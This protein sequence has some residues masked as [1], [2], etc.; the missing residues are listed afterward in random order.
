MNIEYVLQMVCACVYVN[1]DF[2]VLSLL[3]KVT[4]LKYVST[5]LRLT[6]LHLWEVIMCT[7]TRAITHPL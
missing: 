7:Q 6:Y 4:L 5:E 2:D 1:I 3:V